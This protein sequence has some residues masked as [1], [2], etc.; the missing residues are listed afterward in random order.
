MPMA[1]CALFFGCGEAM[2]RVCADVP[3]LFMTSL[4]LSQHAR[5]S[6]GLAGE[7]VSDLY[8][9][10]PDS[11]EV[12]VTDQSED[13]N[14]AVLNSSSSSGSS[15]RTTVGRAG[16]DA[17]G[18]GRGGGTTNGDGVLATPPSAFT[19]AAAPAAYHATTSK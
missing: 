7:A 5:S 15:G 6:L 1:L 19:A 16:G 2:L 10:L 13:N 3:T 18:E 12:P 9:R 17:D 4:L 8:A 14:I 11:P